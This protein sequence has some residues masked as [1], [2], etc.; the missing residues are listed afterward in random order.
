MLAKNNKSDET[1]A[2]TC[3]EEKKRKKNKA[4]CIRLNISDL[5]LKRE[6]RWREKATITK[7]KSLANQLDSWSVSYIDDLISSQ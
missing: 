1:N 3:L 5:C 7:S 4:K 2:T 6:Q